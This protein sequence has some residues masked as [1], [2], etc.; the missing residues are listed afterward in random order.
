[1]SQWRPIRTA[2][3][4]ELDGPEIFFIGG[5]AMSDGVMH[6]AT[7]YANKYGVYEWWGGEMTP[8]HWMP[9]PDINQET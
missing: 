7:C 6:V 8:T 1:M 4:N 9:L 5:R 2:P 3:P